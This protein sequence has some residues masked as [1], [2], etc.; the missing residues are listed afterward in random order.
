MFSLLGAGGQAIVNW[1]DARAPKAAPKPGSGFW[2]K[3]NPIKRLSDEDYVNILEEK[4]L[5]VETDIALMDDRIKEL[6]ESEGQ[7]KEEG[8]EKAQS[9]PSSSSEA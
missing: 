9:N 8:L 1:R 3:W 5:R 7:K 4:L 6:R 2:A